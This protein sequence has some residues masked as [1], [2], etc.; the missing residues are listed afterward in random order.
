NRDAASS[1]AGLEAV[2][3]P[4]DPFLGR[5][6]AA[7]ESLSY[8]L[9]AL[10]FEISEDNGVVVGIAEVGHRVIKQRLDLAP[11]GVG[12]G[13]VHSFD[14]ELF[15]VVSAALAARGPGGHMAC[16]A[17]EPRRYDAILSQPAGF[18]SQQ[19]E[20]PMRDVRVQMAYL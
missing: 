4:R 19:H 13:L 5:V 3:R 2:Q 20:H 12:S 15:A 14:G 17:I 11:G 1:E 9:K 18:P 7:T 10:V 16:S 6:L 8:L